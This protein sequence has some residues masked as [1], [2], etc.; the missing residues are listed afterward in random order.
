MGILI[1]LHFITS[2][3]TSLKQ[4]LLA[5]VPNKEEVQ[6]PRQPNSEDLVWSS[7]RSL[8]TEPPWKR[9][10]SPTPELPFLISEKQRTQYC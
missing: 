1:S 5:R 8:T 9:E 4:M 7:N 10:Y 2:T 3:V 6:T